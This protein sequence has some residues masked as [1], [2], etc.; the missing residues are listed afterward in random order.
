MHEQEMKFDIVIIGGGLVGMSLAVGL[1]KSTCSVLLIEQNQSSPLHDNVL[2][3]R[4]TGLTLSSQK[5]FTQIGLWDNIAIQASPIMRLDISEQGN[6][7]T[8]RIDSNEHGISPIGYMVPNHH[9]MK[10]LSDEVATIS[11]LTVLSPASCQS[12]QQTDEGYEVTFEHEGETK[13]VTTFLLVGADGANSK[14]RELLAISATHKEYEQSAI[15]TNVETQKSHNQVAYERFTQHGP[16]AVLPIKQNHC[17]LIWTQPQEHA[18]HYLQISDKEFLNTLQKAFGYRLGKFLAVG[19][20]VAYPLSMTAS[21]SLVKNNAVLIGNA[22]QTVHPVAAQGFN[23]GLRD[24]HTLVHMLNQIEYK[25]KSFAAML[26]EYEQFRAP[27]RQHVMRLTDGL[28]RLF[29][30]QVWP[31][32]FLR[33]LGVRMV[34]SLTAAQRSVLRRNMGTRYLLGLDVDS[35]G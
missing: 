19:K 15:I 34:G 30:P 5:M 23:L 28:T 26:L 11:N 8:A 10:V 13:H 1:S 17:A 35:H 2:D 6:F 7:G 18:E 24:V 12:I 20:R 21:D 32:K 16:L 4:T 29:K 14:V 33:G 22:A 9:L 3:L 27:D 25:P 31:V